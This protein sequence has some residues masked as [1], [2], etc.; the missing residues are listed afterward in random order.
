MSILECAGLSHTFGDKVLY[1]SASFSL[2]AGEHMGVV[3]QN[4]TGK[5]TLIKILTGEILPDQ[6]TI[7][8]NPEIRAGSLSQYAEIDGAYTVRDYLKTAFTALYEIEEQMTLFYEQA[9]GP[10]AEEAL[11]RAADCQQ[12]LESRDFYRV[13]SEIDRV[14]TGLGIDAFGMQT[15]LEQLSGGQRTR[16]ILAKLLLEK[17][18]LLLLD[19]PTNF[20]DREHVQWLSDYLAAFP[21]ALMVVSHDF[22]FLERITNCILDIEF[23]SMRKYPGRYSHYARQKGQL[24]ADY[25]RQYE[26]QRKTIEKTEAFI[27]KNKAGVNSKMARGRQKQLDR[28]ERLAPPSGSVRPVLRFSEPPLASHKA[29]VVEN[30]EVGYES[31]LLPRLNFSVRSGQKLVITGFNGVG[32]STLLKTLVGAIPALSGAFRFSETAR[33]GYYEQDLQWAGG[34]MTPIGVIHEA[35]PRLTEKEIRSKLAQCGV[36]ND[37]ARQALR[38]LSGG[39]QSRVK[40]CRLLLFPRN[41]LILDEPTNHLDAQTKEALR[42]ALTGFQGCVVVVSHEEGFYRDWADEVFAIDRCY[43]EA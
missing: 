20:L 11:A 29:L 42:D 41:F 40:L 35:D 5:S 17:A 3:G 9:A 25:I 16:V 15:M 21:G 28:L 1:R 26:A 2:F 22:D 23:Q 18:D 4:G 43:L 36:K 34:D 12:L 24:R 8:R 19:E 39:E 32:K 14:S 10:G 7:K 27:R 6:G 37:S 38:T 30:L 33:V 31:A 13:D